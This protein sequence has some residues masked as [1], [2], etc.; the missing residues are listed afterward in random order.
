[1]INRREFVGLGATSLISCAR[2]EGAYFGDTTPP[3]TQRLMFGLGG[4][5]ESLDPAKSNASWEFYIIPM[6]FEGLTQFHPERTEPVAALAT[7]FERTYDHTRYTFCLRGHPAPRGCKLAGTEDM[8]A[9]FTRGRRATAIR[10]PACWSD[11]APIT[12]HDFVYS[13]RRFV[14]PATAAPLAYQMFY[15]KNAEDIYAGK[16][17]LSEMGVRALNDFT[18]EVDLPSPTPFFL[19]LVTNYLFAAVPRQ[20]IEMAGS[21]WTEPQHIVT[22]GPFTLRE[23]RRR[24]KLTTIRNPSYYDEQ[25]VALD[26]VIFYSISDQTASVNL[27]KKGELS[28]TSGLSLAPV[29][30]PELSPKKDFRAIPSMGTS[31]AAMNT[32]RP[33]FDR[34]LVRYAVNMAINKK[35]LAEL[36]GGG[37]IPAHNILFPFADYAPPTTL[38]VSLDSR[39]FDVLPFNP[40]GARLLLTQAMGHSRLEF[41]YHCFAL[42]QSRLLAEALQQQWRNLLDARVTLSVHDS[43]VLWQMVLNA[44]YTGMAD[45]FMVANYADPTPFLDPFVTASS[46]NPSGWTDARFTLALANANRTLEKRERMRAFSKCEQLLLEGMPV[47]PMY[48]ETSRYLIKPF[49]RGLASNA[50]DLRSFKYAWIDTKWR[51]S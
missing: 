2:S 51:P 7:H 12:A 43:S 47:V 17:S 34:K 38:P 22:S 18:L 10:E 27:Y 8:P 6:L 3:R 32:R 29:F 1:M 28:V 25:M 21:A 5:P 15:L 26:E 31:V 24:E 42:S 39:T 9:E 48:H 40:E 20:A 23:W 49:V 14:N 30:M 4:D 37:R 45:C 44:D 46:G 19:Q 16:R 36:V 41:T 33:P 50:I 11:G 13:W 35:A